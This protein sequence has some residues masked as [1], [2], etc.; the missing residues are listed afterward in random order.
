MRPS[1]SGAK[2]I[3]YAAY[4]SNLH[5]LRL[6][7]RIS[8]ARLITTSLLSDWSLYFHKR[9]D[10]RSAKC[11]ILAG[12][13]GVHC[14]IYEIS[15]KDKLILDKIE[16]VGFGYSETTLTI[17]KVGD[18]FAYV[19]E[20]T[21]IDDSLLPYD[22]YHELVKI[23]ARLHRFPADYLKHIES[24]QALNDPDPNRSAEKWKTVE[25]IRGIA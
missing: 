10:D 6:R 9:G 7:K 17:P 4:G 8:S 5:P 1:R 21:H 13:G 14:A 16:G 20:D 3:R 24:K 12:G 15:T 25:M 22:W 11:N 2:K 23:G 18:C 19:A